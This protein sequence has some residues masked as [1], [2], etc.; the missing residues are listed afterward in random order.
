MVSV[1]TVFVSMFP[2]FSHKAPLDKRIE[3]VEKTLTSIRDLESYLSQIKQDMLDKEKA[4]EVINQKYAQAKE[5]EKITD[6]QLVALQST[7][8]K[9]N[10]RWTLFNYV[11]GFV[12]GVASSLL[13]SVIHARWK[14][15]KALE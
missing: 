12:L 9:Q 8:Q 11:M 15:R 14:Q 5:L 7:L 2:V 13:A 1:F 6:A 10:W 4:T 3:T